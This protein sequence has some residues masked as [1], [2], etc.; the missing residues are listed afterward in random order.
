MSTNF[1]HNRISLTVCRRV[2][3][4]FLFLLLCAALR[5]QRWWLPLMPLLRR[6]VIFF[7]FFFL[8]C[9]EFAFYFSIVLSL[10]EFACSP[11]AA[12]SFI[13]LLMLFHE[14]FIAHASRARP[15]H[16]CR[17]YTPFTDCILN[18]ILFRTSFR[19]S[20]Y[21]RKVCVDV[22][23]ASWFSWVCRNER[24]RYNKRSENRK[25]EEATIATASTTSSPQ[26]KYAVMKVLPT[27][28]S[29][30][31]F[32]NFIFKRNLLKTHTRSL[33]NI[34]QIG[35]WPYR[36]LIRRLSAWI[37]RSEWLIWILKPQSWKTVIAPGSP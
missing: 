5:H 3:G 16:V 1:R 19:S 18:V 21:K 35:E 28:F 36:Q 29:F 37:E 7:C 22:C 24:S 11:F 12:V 4:N 13:F 34:E 31:F 2:T 9:L 23:C 6:F 8:P 15:R 27:F 30:F 14:M 20:S 32:S 33:T 26:S 17:Q 25:N 10:V